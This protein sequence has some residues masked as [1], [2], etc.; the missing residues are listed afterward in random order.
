[1]KK[2]YLILILF[3]VSFNI[4]AQQNNSRLNIKSLRLIENDTE[5]SRAMKKDINGDKCALIKIQTPNM[6]ESERNRLQFSAD[7]GTSVFNDEKAV[8][9]VKL[10]LTEGCKTLII[11]HPDYGKLTYPMPLSVQGWKTYEMVLMADKKDDDFTTNTLTLN[12]NY[13]IINV[14]PK[15]ALI[16]V[17]GKLCPTGKVNLT[18]DEPHHLEVSHKLYHTYES[19]IYASETEKL[20]YDVN[21]A[22]AHGWLK[23][24]SKPESGAILLIDGERKGV[25]PYT[26]E[27]ITSGEHEVTLM[28]DMFESSTF[29]IVVKDS[30]T[31]ELELPMTPTFAEVTVTTDSESEIYI[32]GE[33]KRAGKWQGRLTEGQHLLEARKASHRTTAMQVEIIAGKDESFTIK[34]PVPIYGALDIQSEPDEAEVYLDGVKIGETPL[35]KK[36]VLVGNRTVRFEKKGC[37]TLTKSYKVEENN[38]L[39]VYEKLDSGKI[40]SIT[41]D[42]EGDAIYVDGTYAGVS[43]LEVSMGY[44]QHTVKAERD[45]RSVVKDIDVKVNGTQTQ[46]T[47]E[48]GKLIT[49]TTGRNGDA[50]YVDGTYAGVSPLEVS[51]GYGQHTVKAERDGRSVVKD[52]D[53]K[54]NGTQTQLTLEFGKLITVT[55]GR[56]GDAI[57]VDGAYA[58]VSPLEVSM[59]FG[60]HTVKAERDGKSVEKSLEVRE[61]GGESSLHIKFIVNQ[62]ITVNG[63]SFEMVYVEGGTFKMGATSEQGRDAYGKEKPVHSVTLSDYYIGKYEVTQELWEAVMGSNP[64]ID[65]GKNNPVGSVSYNDCQEFIK[66][67]N[68]LT[69]KNFRLPTEAEW[70]YAARGGNKSRHY[71]YSGSNNID[72]VAWYYYNSGVNTHP[73]GTRSPNELGIYNMS[74]NV[75]EWCLDWYGSYS[76]GSQTNPQGPSTGSGR[77]L[78]GGGCVDGA[79]VCRV[80]YRRNGDPSLGYGDSGLRLALVP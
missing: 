35:K 33:K 61:S 3:C 49:V 19:E 8:G 17:D 68:S 13:V 77:V 76:R 32:D 5:A 10:F 80:S 7:M 51:M 50:I 78:R 47:L 43:P 36:D 56:N 45:G 1:M 44:G 54:V 11:M 39:S 12:S 27:A 31:L 38:I 52:I 63:V 73:V 37:V 42:K 79:R 72:D 30:K 21:L 18:I 4:H 55:T 28:M 69:G 57:Y 15:D 23:I 24:D 59:G 62:T 25:T 2:L 46:L 75:C 40:I 34:S 26:S 48:F 70:E 66:R 22:P 6:N 20:Q 58:G 41:T 74:G 60:K 53:V 16:N 64:S 67:L 9:E 71:K 29:T 14:T 65:I